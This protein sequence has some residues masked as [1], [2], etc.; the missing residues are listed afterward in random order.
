MKRLNLNET[1]KLCLSMWRW[2]AKER[3]R[4]NETSVSMLKA[5]WLCKHGF[6]KDSVHNDCFFC[7]YAAKHEVYAKTT[8]S[9]CSDC[10]GTKIGQ[11]FDCMNSDYNYYHKPI[12]FYK[13]LLV[14][15]KTRRAKK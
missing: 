3:K 5:E 9:D 14:L 2:I 6:K 11:N 7:E 13:K 10:P 4:G 15:N 12:A 1:W 8:G